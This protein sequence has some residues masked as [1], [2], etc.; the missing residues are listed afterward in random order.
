[1]MLMTLLLLC[2]T[3][4]LLTLPIQSTLLIQ[5]LMVLGVVMVTLNLVMVM[6]PP[7]ESA[8]RKEP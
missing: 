7:S 1:M 2:V 4:L 8:N 6:L 3:A 5:A